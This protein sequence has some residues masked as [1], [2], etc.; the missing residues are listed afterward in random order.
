MCVFFILSVLL[1]S[2]NFITPVLDL[3]IS[4]I[5]FSPQ[6]ND[7]F[8]MLKFSFIVEKSSHHEAILLDL[9]FCHSLFSI[10]FPLVLNKM[11]TSTRLSAIVFVSSHLS[12]PPTTSSSFIRVKCKML[13]DRNCRETS[14]HSF[15][16][17]VLLFV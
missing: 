7:I 14:E 13:V 4:F 2:F 11:F 3:I 15:W 8:S 10:P 12:S 9:S 1:Y 6:N 16:F 17:S 5:I